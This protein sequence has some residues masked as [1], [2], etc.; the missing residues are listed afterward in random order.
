MKYPNRFVSAATAFVVAA[1]VLLQPIARACM[2]TADLTN[3][4]T[5]NF[6]AAATGN[7]NS[8]GTWA[9]G[10]VPTAG[11]NV[12]IPLGITVTVNSQI[13][14]DYKKIHVE[15]KLQFAAAATSRL[16]FDTI[17]V[18]G[19]LQAGTT[20]TPLTGQCELIVVPTVPLDTAERGRG[21]VSEGTVSMVGQYKTPFRAVSSNAL[22]GATSLTLLSAPTGWAV[23]NELLVASTHFSRTGAMQNEFRTLNAINTTAVTLNSALAHAHRRPR[24]GKEFH[25]A[26][27]T[28]N[29]VVK[30]ENTTGKNRGHVMFMTGDVYL[31]SVVFRD[32]GR[33]DKTL[34]TSAA[35]PEGRYSCHFHQ[36][37]YA[38]MAQVLD[39]VVYNSPGWGFVNHSSWVKFS[40]CVAV[41]VVGSAFNAEAGDEI[42]S[43]L[44]NFAAHGAGNGQFFEDGDENLDANTDRV[45]LG[46]LAWTGVG[47]WFVSPRINVDNNVAAGLKGP[48][49]AFMTVGKKENSAGGKYIG[50]PNNRVPTGCTPRHWVHNNPWT[51][52]R[53]ALT[54]DM[55]ILSF[56]DNTVYG[57]FQGT[58]IRWMGHNSERVYEK[59]GDF[60]TA[61]IDAANGFVGI[62]DADRK[63]TDVYRL[64]AWNVEVGHHH[65]Y[66]EKVQRDGLSAEIDLNVMP[67]QTYGYDIAQ[68]V[69]LLNYLQNSSA[70]R[71]LTG[72]LI[73]QDVVRTNMTFT[74]CNTNIEFF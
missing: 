12:E 34:I 5:W 67:K 8:P 11:A 59:T 4:V 29:I 27:L 41:G 69:D 36:N 15:G 74:E 72:A 62:R 46:D 10:V 65:R 50:L 66:Q 28:R 44:G 48:G 63:Q 16:K 20:T 32:L 6:T 2:M 43:F 73:D 17:I 49:L 58:R 64:H 21:I 26:N 68:G 38:T 25:V 7:W 47:F 31:S 30:S 54:S 60:T 1:L 14:V 33:T 18:C 56:Q 23:G 37:R 9:Q 57:S 53:M 45:S 35:N 51:G 61:K 42:G 55:P 24:A 19:T 52:E 40:E 39:C 22:A 71:F 3:G 13:N 70:I